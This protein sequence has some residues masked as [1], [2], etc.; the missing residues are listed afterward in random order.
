[1][2][3]NI[4]PVR[5][6]DALDS[7]RYGHKAATLAAL[8][9]DGHN[10]PD[11]FVI[12]VG[13][14][15]DRDALLGPLAALGAG[16]YAVRSSG[17]AED[18]AGASF[19][20][21]YESVIGVEG[22]DD[23]VTAA[24][25]VLASG[26]SAR[27]AAYRAD[28]DAAE[29][30]LAVLVQRLVA[31][32]AAGVMFTRNPVTGDD[33]L[34][35][36]AVRGLGDRLVDGDADAERWLQRGRELLAPSAPSVLDEPAVR[37]LLELGARIE[38]ER[39]EPQDIEWALAGGELFVL[40][41]RPITGLPRRPQIEVP[42]GRWTK[43][44]GHFTGPVTPAAAT[45]LLPAYEVAMEAAFADFG[46]PIKTIRQRSF[47]GE[48]YTQDVDLDGK[49]HPEAPPPWWLLGVLVRV[50]PSLRRTMRAAEA[51]IAKLESYP[52]RWENEWRPAC[53]ARVE[54]A[55]AV[56]LAALSDAE[57]QQHFDELCEMLVSHLTLH[58]QL[59]MPHIV[60]VYELKV[61]TEE[62]LGWDFAKTLE[63]LA[64]RS[65]T[66]VA[67][68]RELE[69]VA[70]ELD[71]E[72]IDRGL[73]AVL[74]SPAGERMRKWLAHWGL[75]TVDVDPGTPML[76]ER[77]ELVLSLLREAREGKQRNA[78]AER[79]E[80]RAALE[81]ARAALSGA[82]RER[83]EAA[84]AYAEQV[85][86]NRD[87]NVVYTEGFSCGLVRRASLEVAR[88]LVARG[89]LRHATD[90]G[91][92]ERA[93]MASALAGTLGGESATERVQRR[94]AEEA[95][96]RAHPGPPL[97]GPAPVPPPSLRG[98]PP[99]CRRLMAAGLWAMN[100]ELAA[101]TAQR[102][103][104][105]ALLGVP[106]SPGRYTGP[107]RV[108][109]TEAELA[110]LRPGEVLVCPSTHSSWT[111]VFGKVGALVADGGSILSHPAIIAREH[112]IPA[113]V[114][115]ISG[116]SSLRNGELVTVDGNIGRVARA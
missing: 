12:P 75:R 57:L 80:R 66:T 99:A 60:G 53:A 18:L 61:C 11:G 89:L 105:G 14:A 104:D 29:G 68:T 26:K 114:G 15:W 107:V 32:E 76:S 58:F 55:L 101:P 3:E 10:V 13:M 70:R 106:V 95:W 112:G 41:A 1:M 40:Q 45:I 33:E 82:D 94:R 102:S 86:G 36:E 92:L 47:G 54:A 65:E 111:V 64:G 63:L 7:A 62:L 73:A 25:R 87:D 78:G 34:V 71:A 85:Y 81:Q 42:T 51:A 84:L 20:G 100:T 113:V 30:R 48:V 83:F 24:G 88:R 19:A 31:A 108:I 90:I 52:R 39:G 115:T 44:T 38:R 5:L 50:I 97:H 9:R 16:P 103:D 79:P 43:D 56:D 2:P 77:E 17:V 37:R 116:T 93:E 59:T 69:D 22:I 67:A 49:H 91:Y 46:V 27:V 28:V 21:Q 6:D 72:L 35:L 23:V 74:A 4:V 109:R 96:V 8:R 110:E 98:L